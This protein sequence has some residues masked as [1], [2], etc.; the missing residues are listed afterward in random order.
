MNYQLK[1]SYLKFDLISED[2]KREP[3]I[4]NFMSE[5]K[6]SY[7]KNL[8]VNELCASCKFNDL[9]CTIFQT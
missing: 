2:Q 8:N 6:D 9:Y 7:L 4:N 1:S 5:R 3:G